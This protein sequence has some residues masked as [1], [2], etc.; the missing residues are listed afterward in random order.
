MASDRKI[1]RIGIV[2]EGVT[3]VVVI[4]SIVSLLASNAKKDYVLSHIQPEFDAIDNQWSPGG[5]GNVYRW[6][7][8]KTDLFGSID[9]NPFLS[10]FD[11]LIIHLDIDVCQKKYSDYEISPADDDLTLPISVSCSKTSCSYSF[12]CLMVDYTEKLLLSWCKTTQIPP[13]IIFCLPSKSME[14][15]I[16]A[17]LPAQEPFFNAKTA[18]RAK[19]QM[20]ANLECT[21]EPD[22]YFSRMKK[23]GRLEKKEQKYKE[24]SSVFSANWSVVKN[25]CYMAKK[26]E[27]D[28]VEKLK[29]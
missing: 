18:N 17:S 23:E 3:D 1:L 28:I 9:L 6:C 8:E 27:D 22:K 19:K 2:A 20:M 16:V 11:I 26:F 10:N 21:L 24:Y 7:S 13:N 5:W 25:H 15:W 12:P 14:A 29:N 4:D